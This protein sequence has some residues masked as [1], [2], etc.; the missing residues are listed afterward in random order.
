M[1]NSCHPSNYLYH[2]MLDFF[3]AVDNSGAACSLYLI[4]RGVYVNLA[5]GKALLFL[6]QIVKGRKYLNRDHR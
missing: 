2:E 1:S 3:T 6:P 4:Y 5:R